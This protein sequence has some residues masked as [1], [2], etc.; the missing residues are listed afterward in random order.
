MNKKLREAIRDLTH[1]AAFVSAYIKGLPAHF[2]T[3]HTAGAKLTASRK[4]VEELLIK[5]KEA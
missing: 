5:N 2:A 1:E 3:G 4:L